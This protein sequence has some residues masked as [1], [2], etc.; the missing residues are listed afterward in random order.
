LEVATFEWVHGYNQPRLMG[1][2]GCIPPA[3]AE[4]NYHRERAVLVEAA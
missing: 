1:P 3:E 2:L 4:A